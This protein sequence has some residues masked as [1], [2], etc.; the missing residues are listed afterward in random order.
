MQLLV[1]WFVETIGQTTF[2][3]IVSVKVTGRKSFSTL[4]IWRTLP[5]KAIDSAILLHLTVFQDSQLSLFSL[6]PVLF[7]SA[8][9]LLPSLSSTTTSQHK[10]KSG[11]L[12]NVV[13]GQRHPSS[14]CLPATISLCWSGG[15]PSLS[16]IL[17]FTFSIVSKGL[18]LR[19]MLFPV[20]VFTKICIMVAVPPQMVYPK[21]A[22]LFSMW[23]SGQPPSVS[24][25]HLSSQRPLVRFLQGVT[26]LYCLEFFILFYFFLIG[27]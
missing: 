13:V 21:V 9:R 12:L 20:K 16:W 11:L 18:T 15:T 6:M 1:F 4:F 2:A 25:L 5:V 26:V 8:V 23:A 24:F 7:G 27:V 22:F 17:A 10:M 19:E 3:I 14:S